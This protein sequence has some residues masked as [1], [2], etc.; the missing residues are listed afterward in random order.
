MRADFKRLFGALTSVL[1]STA[2]RRL[3]VSALGALAIGIMPSLPAIGPSGIQIATAPAA[4]STWLTRLN[5]WRASTGVSALSENTLWSQGDYAHSLYMVKNDLVTHYETPGTPYYTTAGDTAARD[6]NINVSSTTSAT[7]D[8]AIDWWMGAPFHAMGLMDPRLTQT[9]FGSYR[10]VKSGWQM[11]AAVDVIRGNSFTGGQFPVFFPGN[12]TTEPLTSYSGNEF[13]DPLQACPGYATPT[14]LPVF[15]EVGGNVA[16]TAG[17]VHS[18]TGNG[19]AL[20]HCVIDSS[21]SALSSYLTARGGVILIPRQPLQTGVKYVVAL[22]VNGSPYTWS[23]TVGA[24]SPCT[25][26]ALSPTT[27]GPVGAG[28][29]ITF[30]ASSTGCPNARYAFWVQYPDASWHFLQNFGGPSFK[31]DTTGL[32]SGAYLV[33]VWAN[34]GGNGYDAIGS[35]TATLTTCTSASLS[36]TNPT[37]AAGSTFNFTASSTG[38]ANPRYA[39]WVQYPDTSWHFV[40]GFGA[41]TFGW[42]TTGLSI[43]TYTVHAWVNEAGNSYEAIGSA[44]ATLTGCASASL[45]PSSGSA[46]VGT[47]VSFT[48]GSAGCAN[49]RYAF[50]VQNPD[51]SWHFMQG[52]GGPAFTWKTAGLGKG[53]YTIH[54]W[55]NTQGNGYDTIGAATYTLT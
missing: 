20:A 33:H 34:S 42:P 31:W 40:Q 3:A 45:S 32:V 44:T 35:A 19:V 13:P 16:T 39:F 47:A 11:G 15:I 48:A 43:G 38:C 21:N 24:F 29:S 1:S 52:F 10:E 55:V 4:S 30:T 17:S 12:A 41:A 6:S 36:P 14:G 51:A 25:S 2:G 7:D 5:S 37:Q 53:A 9:G 27:A 23:F 54:V 28:T 18:F 49:P 8:Q 50:W 26:A 22:T 46:A